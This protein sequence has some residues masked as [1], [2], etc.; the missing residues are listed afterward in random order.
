MVV[1]FFF[2]LLSP[3]FSDA[4]QIFIAEVTF[5]FAVAVLPNSSA[6]A[7]RNRCFRAVFVQRV[8]TLS[9]IVGPISADLFDLAGHV[10]E[11]IRQHFGIAD[12]VGAGDGA[13]DFQRRFVHAQMQFEPGAAL[14]DAV[15]ADFP[16]AFA[17]DF[18]AR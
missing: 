12:V 8:V 16:F 1:T 10:F 11:Q 15:L 5:S 14:A 2:P 17:V 7:W 13:D 9:L 3:D 4:P 6:F 18:G